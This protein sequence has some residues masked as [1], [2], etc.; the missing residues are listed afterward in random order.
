MT[1]K[2]IKENILPH[3]TSF[4]NTYEEKE[5]GY[6]KAMYIEDLARA[7]RSKLIDQSSGLKL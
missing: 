5:I 1:G 6:G 7:H 2:V 3:L 4:Q